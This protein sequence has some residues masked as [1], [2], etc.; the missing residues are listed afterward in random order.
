M[1]ACEL[2]APPSVPRVTLTI[3]HRRLPH[4]LST[5]VRRTRCVRPADTK[6]GTR[7]W[8]WAAA[9]RTRIRAP[10]LGTAP[11][12]RPSAPPLDN[13]RGAALVDEERRSV[14]L[15]QGAEFHQ[16]G[17]LPVHGEQPVK[18][19]ELIPCAVRLQ[20]RARRR[21]HHQLR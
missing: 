4:G 19:T 14:L 5:K 3:Q 11:R 21:Q 6:A 16:R 8:R 20:C 10:P 13:A 18:S 9:C 15:G 2:W 7:R 12:H 17:H 1:R